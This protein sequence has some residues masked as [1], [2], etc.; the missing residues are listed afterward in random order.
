M[1]N[2]EIYLST[3]SDGNLKSIEER[4]IK[5]IK[6]QITNDF[7]DF[8]GEITEEVDYILEYIKQVY[9]STDLTDIIENFE[10]FSIDSESEVE[11]DF[12]LSNIIKLFKELIGIRFDIDRETISF[13][14]IYNVYVI[15]V[16]SLKETVIMSTKGFYSLN[17]KND[18]KITS[19][20]I[21]EYILSDEF[22][23]NDDFI[24]NAAFV[25]QNELIKKIKNMIDDFLISIDDSVFMKFIYKFITE[26]EFWLRINDGW[27]IK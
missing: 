2:D 6:N 21:S 5:K 4:L 16:L 22:S 3:I 18:V 8:V 25:S 23:S 17:G 14:D 27:K 20:M 19:D 7:G 26:T 12:I 9:I 1:Y 13:E 15:F 24:R 10:Q 11:Y